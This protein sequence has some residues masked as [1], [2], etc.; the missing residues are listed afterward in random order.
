MVWALYANTTLHTRIIDGDILAYQEESGDTHLFHPVTY[1]L[2]Q[3][4]AQG[5]VEQADIVE[6]LQHK[7]EFDRTVLSELLTE[8]L[9]NLERN[10][11]LERR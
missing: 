11:I 10:G 8:V 6:G 3:L 4:L 1:E 9:Q 7:F 2:L 5:P